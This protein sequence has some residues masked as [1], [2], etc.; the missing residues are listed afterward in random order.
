M[1]HAIP[2]PASEYWDLRVLC[3]TRELVCQIEK[4][5]DRFRKAADLRVATLYGGV[6]KATQL[7]GLRARPQLVIA[8]PGRLADLLETAGASCTLHHVTFLVL[9]EADRMLDDGFEESVRALVEQAKSPRRQTLLFSATWPVRV[10]SLA[11]DF[12][13]DPV[14][15]NA[16]AGDA[17]RANPSITQDVMFVEEEADKAAALVDLLNGRP[18]AQTLV[19]VSTK[20]ACHQLERAIGGRVRGACDA[21][22]GDRSQQEREAVLKA[23]RDCQIRVLFGT[24]VASRGLDI[25]GVSLVVN[26]D[27]PRSSEDYVHRI[28]RTGRAGIGGVAISILTRGE[29]EAA[30][31]IAAVIQISGGRMPPELALRLGMTLKRKVVG[32]GCDPGPKV[33]EPRAPW[34]EKWEGVD[35]E[36]KRYKPKDL[37]SAIYK[38]W[39]AEP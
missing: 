33:V 30:R 8:T 29:M 10:Q 13:K 12:T 1:L 25:K 23:F 27:A 15:V 21:I 7:A 6:P 22:H 4:E 11:A 19:F 24:D 34:R 3:P 36:A 26:F 20:R 32:S 28:G 5:A 38:M 16:G 39:S 14:E 9:D 37:A 17:L 18:K 35:P 31:N 2:L